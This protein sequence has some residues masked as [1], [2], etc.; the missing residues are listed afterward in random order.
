MTSVERV[1]EYTNL[2]PEAKL[3]CDKPPGDSWPSHGCVTAEQVSFKYKSDGP[4][5]LNNLTFAIQGQEKVGQIY[6]FEAFIY[7]TIK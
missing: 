1:F 5:V 4:I 3:E 7:H 2:E 6:C